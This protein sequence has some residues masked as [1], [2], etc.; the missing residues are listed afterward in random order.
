[1][2]QSL[3]ESV[4]A[5]WRNPHRRAWLGA[6]LALAL[7]LPL[8]VQA[9][10]W[11]ESRLLAEERSRLVLESSLY[12]NAIS[13][14]VNRRTAL[15]RG[16]HAFVEAELFEEAFAAEFAV[17]ANRLQLSAAGI[18]NIAV[19]PDGIVRYVYPP[20]PDNLAVIGYEPLLDPRPA[21][22]QDVQRAIDSQ[23]VVLS[24][25]HELLQGGEGLIARQAVFYE[26]RY[27]GLLNI[28]FDLPPLLEES[29]L[30]DLPNSSNFLLRDGANGSIIF[31]VGQMAEAE[32]VRQ[33]IP[34][35]D[36]EWELLAAPSAGW[37]ALIRPSLQLFQ[38]TGL[39][40]LLLLSG[41]T[42]LV[43]SRQASLEEG[44]RS[45]TQELAQVN[46][47]LQQ[48]LAQRA[49][50]RQVLEQRVAERTREL[51]TLLDMSQQMASVLEHRP[52]LTIILNQLQTLVDYTEA[53]ISVRREDVYLIL[54]YR[55]SFASERIV[56]LET[57]PAQ[58]PLLFQMI[59][60]GQSLLIADIA[61]ATPLAKEFRTSAPDNLE[62]L[63]DRVR[64]FLAVPLMV[65]Q[66]VVGF[67]GMSH[68]RP[69]YYTSRDVEMVT[70]VANQAAIAIE[71][72]RL[73]EQAQQLAALQERQR[74]ARE[75]H[76]SVSQAL[77]G[78]ALGARTARTLL[79]RQEAAE[80]LPALLTDPLDYVLS[81]AEA[82]LAEMR[83]LIFELRPESLATEGLMTALSKQTAALQARHHLTIET[84]LASEPDL[85]LN[86]KE[87]LYRVAQEALNNVVKHARAQ[88]VTVKLWCEETA[89]ATESESAVY[90]EIQD[91][92]VGF[93]PAGPFPGHLGLHSMRER[94]ERLGG[95]LRLESAPGAGTRL[96]VRIGNR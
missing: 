51:T 40:I 58:A 19:A 36:G 89:A 80:Q 21:V 2:N 50:D 93:D 13:S 56:G 54:D 33:P 65:K 44:I 8:W 10:R 25:P 38:G 67:L 48:E 74:L 30:T 52:L 66:D 85:P 42:Y 6:L 7:L 4:V 35:P 23:Q 43:L 17:F 16:L 78:I 47:Q 91:D 34:L 27:W 71:N 29:G 32:P 11:Y 59:E 22:Q 75:L 83:A 28:A 46:A 79:G 15:M 88:T 18:H 60:Q 31:T 1:M 5:Q 69:Y 57:K 53:T 49:Q 26:G 37:A 3:Q 55:G 64:S 81:L 14:A 86:T 90:L 61:E 77:Y 12:A 39:I 95:E 68:R 73:Y 92:G 82:G 84:D 20:N 70:A 72:A 62:E 63:V 94:V 96:W 24:G 41:L 87:A 76:D 9:S 45:R